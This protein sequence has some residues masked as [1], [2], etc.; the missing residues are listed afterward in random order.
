M[1]P[2]QR[3]HPT[4]PRFPRG[5]RT[6]LVAL[7]A[8]LSVSVPAQLAASPAGAAQS[9]SGTSW[10][11]GRW[12]PGPEAYGMETV[13]RVPVK[14]DDGVI[15]PANIGYPT[16]PKTGK[17]AAGAFPVLV[18]QNPY[19]AGGDPEKYF[20]NRGY[21]FVSVDV[22]GT[23]DSSAPGGGPLKQ[24]LFSPRQARDGV[25]V[26]DWAAH[27]LSGSN[28]TV[29]LY[30]CSFL[31]IDQ[32]FT[33]AAVGA[34]SPVKAM[35]PACA[36]NTFDI[37]FSGGV[38][39]P[40]TGLFASASILN[41]L[42]HLTEN[43]ASGKEIADDIQAGGEHA[44]N[45]DYWRVRTTSPQMASNIVRNGVPALLWSGWQAAD[46]TGNLEFLAALQNASFHRPA[47]APLS[48]GSPVTGR[49]QLIMGD[50]G[51]GGGLDKSMELEWYDTWLRG[52]DTGMAST[53]TPLHLNEQ[54]SKRWTNV[55]S[56]PLASRY[57]PF[58]LTDHAGLSPRAPRANGPAEAL[59][60]TAPDQAQ[61]TLSYRTAP[62]LGGA[63]LAGPLAAR[64][65]ASSSNTNLNLIATLRDVAPNGDT[66]KITS[67][68]ILG[69]LAAVD[70]AASWRD[71]AG[72]LILPVHPYT[73]DN[74]LTPG[75]ARAFDIKLNPSLYGLA[76][77]HSLQLVLQAKEGDLDCVSFLGPA[78]PCNYTDPQ[79]AT[80]TGGKYQILHDAAHPSVLTLP[81]LPYRAL[82][83]TVS[84]TTPESGSQTLP[85]RW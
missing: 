19:L 24:E 53:G 63:T 46:G 58:Y 65:Y 51:H 34:G 61:G 32:L 10:P 81:V 79:K 36:S 42:Q 64:V 62:F 16:D 48:P 67:G 73:A 83:E 78:L 80:L 21:I 54:G 33:A 8:G 56:Y 13:S 38:P 72:Q 49:Y 52:Q 9:S 29:G 3:K 77:G 66:T 22:R 17:R 20:V 31:G 71:S 70:E 47:G 15:L 27:Q 45:R 69:S 76:P 39:G 11:G 25:E 37:Y 82:S 14:M 57:S 43:T 1:E 85:L 40:T 55:S 41:G 28:G 44:Y 6:A 68:S 50:W 18:Q 75:K 74:Y 60:W 35:I 23:N 2:L 7:C 5:L 59:A 4:Q 26:V 84:G 30:G 12:Q